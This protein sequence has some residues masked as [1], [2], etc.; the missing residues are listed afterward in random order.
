MSTLRSMVG[1]SHHSDSFDQL[2]TLP[3]NCHAR[4][5]LHHAAVERHVVRHRKRRVLSLVKPLAI[6]RGQRYGEWTTIEPAIHPT[7]TAHRHWLCV[8]SCGVKRLVAATRLVSGKT[9]HCGHTQ[10]R[11]VAKRNTTHGHTKGHGHGRA[12]LVSREYAAWQHM[13]DRCLNPQTQ[14]WRYYGGR[15]ITV[16]D[17]WRSFENFFADMGP[18]PRGFTLDRYPNPDGNYEPGNC[19]WASW[20]QQRANRSAR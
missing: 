18:C 19:R 5:R 16:C 12:G 3:Q 20:K 15:D 10:S 6:C 11:K 7:D 1:A 14:K 17:R 9:T 8:C 13:K 2:P 4:S